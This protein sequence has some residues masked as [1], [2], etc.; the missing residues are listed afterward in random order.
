MISIS[1][2]IFRKY[3]IRGQATGPA[4]DI[5]G[6]VAEAI[7][8][9]Y[10]TYLQQNTN[11]NRVVVGHDN[12]TT[13]D[14]LYCRAIVGL[15]SSGCDVLDIG[16]VSTPLVYWYTVQR[17][18]IAGL[19]ITASH[20]GPENNGFK[21]SIGPQS[22]YGDDI[23]QIY[24][25][26]RDSA[27]CSGN[28][29]V[30]RLPSDEVYH[31]Y[32]DDVAQRATTKRPLNVVI[33]A[34]NGTGGLFS[35]QLIERWGHKVR[36]CL[37]CE[38][39]GR[40]PHHQPDPG[41]AENM[42]ALCAKVRDTGADIGLGFDGD[43]DRLGVVDELGHLIAPDRVLALLAKDT[44]SRHS[45]G[46]ILVDVSS[47]QVVL[48]VV[49]QAGGVPVMC[50]TGHSL[51]K[52]KMAETGA[53]LGGEMSGHIFMAEDYYG[54][55]DA[56]LVAGR[57]L[58]LVSA[59]DQPLSALDNAMPRL[60]STPLYR[61]HCPPEIAE[62]AMQAIRDRLKERGQ[63]V[64]IDGLRMQF[65]DGWGL[66]RPSNTEPVLSMRF[67]GRTEAAML[68]YRDLFFDVLRDFAAIDLEAI[69]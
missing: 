38:P 20:L 57:V 18:G 22:L 61:P 4:P 48:D 11:F 29:S 42:R 24:G 66:I 40:Y 34:G 21:L 33:D 12:R 14:D 63:P 43:A 37:Y 8:R 52:A 56:Y 47:S 51:V 19:M 23:Q 44:L 6:N 17:G 54:F 59:S 60:Y 46:Q 65:A 55:D 50:P 31:R 41:H 9:A 27:Y 25:I 30:E 13:S 16:F 62:A 39:D 58:Q 28:G 36:D 1:P 67:E 45:G 68:A 53:L 2:A 26:I 5:T 64:E 35:T 49:E 3:D 7:G 10:G 32:I 15:T 69:A